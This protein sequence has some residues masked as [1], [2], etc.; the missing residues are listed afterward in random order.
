MSLQESISELLFGDE[1]SCGE[2]DSLEIS[3][4]RLQDKGTPTGVGPS[5]N[6]VENKAKQNTLC[7]QAKRVKKAEK[8][9]PEP[10]LPKKKAKVFKSFPWILTGQ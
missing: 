2:E 1:G 10:E 4:K 8:S 5:P 9:G 7:Q 6:L 3:E